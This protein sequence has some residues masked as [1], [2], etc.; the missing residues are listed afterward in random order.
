MNRAIST[1][2][3]SRLQL[4][5]SSI[6]RPLL[7][8]LATA[9]TSIR[10]ESSNAAGELE[11]SP[12]NKAVDIQ[13]L[14]RN[15]E[16]EPQWE[17]KRRNISFR[18]DFKISQDPETQA[19]IDE[20]LK[21]P[22]ALPA[23][24]YP[25]ITQTKYSAK[26]ARHYAGVLVGHDKIW[27]K[28]NKP[29][30][31]PWE[32]TFNLLKTM[33]TSTSDDNQTEAMRIVL[34]S[35]LELA[36][37]PNQPVR[38][39]DSSTG[40]LSSLRVSSDR[41]HSSSILVRGSRSTL[42]KAADELV[43]AYE[44]VQVYQ[45]GEVVTYDYQF[46]QLWPSIRGAMDGGLELPKNQLDKVWIHP[47]KEGKGTFHIDHRYEDL[48]RPAE[49]T[50][51]SLQDYISDVHYAC[52]VPST[53]SQ[54]YGTALPPARGNENIRL[55]KRQE[56]EADIDAIK[57]KLMYDAINEPSARTCI[58][59][60]T[61]KMALTFMA[62]RGG[63]V[64]AADK[65]LRLAED[66]GLPLNTDIYNIMLHAYV[67][68]T[69]P[70]YFHSFLIKMH[71]RYFSANTRTWLLFLR[72]T[73]D[74]GKRRLVVT[75]MYESGLF[76]YEGLRRQLAE[77]MAPT[78]AY[79]AL[80]SGKTLEDF[81]GE[82]DSFFNC[83][84]WFTHSICNEIL[85]EYLRFRK[86]PFDISALQPLFAK[87]RQDLPPVEPDLPMVNTVLSHAASTRDW[88]MALQAL[89]WLTAENLTPDRE[90]YN[91]LI[92][93]ALATSSPT[94]TAVIFLH[95]TLSLGLK[96]KGTRLALRLAIFGKH[97]NAFWRHNQLPLLDK[98]MPGT[99][100]RYPFRH[101]ALIARTEQMIR[102]IAGD[103]KPVESLRVL[104]EQAWREHD[105][106]M[107]KEK[108][109]QKEKHMINIMFPP[110]PEAESKPEATNAVSESETQS[111]AQTEIEPEYPLVKPKPQVV[112]LWSASEGELTLC[113]DT[114]LDLTR[115]VKD[116]VWTPPRAKRHLTDKPPSRY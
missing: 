76:K 22:Y 35:S 91:H 67:Q 84:D 3:R 4:A 114:P 95:S 81:L 71:N 7:P 79:H 43:T 8:R 13:E 111:Q 6:R 72:L 44:G 116:Y 53:F 57:V 42:V 68:R 93:L 30:E 36:E 77:I 69:N 20:K 86:G 98:S 45:L 94:A 90:T 97:R 56:K 31:V 24:D 63:H 14:R 64:A 88:D 110:P 54:L 73:Q 109:E 38:F 26:Q 23:R 46:R 49:W 21:S 113:L 60:P 25:N 41:S 105:L 65:L 112:K 50:T 29:T 47:E 115:F 104:L 62:S 89:R 106:P 1:A 17:R 74:D 5:S 34:P 92:G 32:S 12:E 100:K 52:M 9:Y 10:Y 37:V 40:I 82:Q 39:I 48:P 11:A 28:L 27:A 2:W 99:C 78:N 16:E 55:A 103:R 51:E 66:W 58:N 87:R 19:A 102:E 59:L 70:N 15:R 96:S 18:N 108:E 83:G 75:A 85:E 80:R 107:Q 33:T 61:L 101:E